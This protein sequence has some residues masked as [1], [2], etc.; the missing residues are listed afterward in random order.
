MITS[1]IVLSKNLRPQPS[2][3]EKILYKA[4]QKEFIVPYVLYI[5]FESFMR[6]S[7]NENSVSEHVP[8]GFCCLKVSKFEDEIFEPF[9]YS[10]PNLV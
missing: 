6:P 1:S 10:G 9:V 4:I 3:R 8:F 2:P 7:V 5:D